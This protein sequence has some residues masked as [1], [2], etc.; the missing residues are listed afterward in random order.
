MTTRKPFTQKKLWLQ[1]IKT[2]SIALCLAS[3]IQVLAQTASDEIPLLS[4]GKP[5]LTGVWGNGDMSFINPV[6]DESGSVVCI[7]GCAAPA[8]AG[9]AAPS[10]APAAAPRGPDRPVYKPEYVARVQELNERQVEMD[11]ALS[12]GNPGLPRIGPPEGIV[13]RADQIVLLYDDLSGSFFRIIPTDGR[14]Q[15]EPTEESYLGTSV[16]W[17]EDDTLVIQAGNFN[18]ITWL[19][20][21]GAFHTKELKVTER[22][23]LVGDT[24]EYQAIV[25]DP[26]VLAEPWHMRAR[27]LQREEGPLLEP[28]PC[29]ENDL[30]H[31]VDGTHHDNAR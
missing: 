25:E 22:L 26:A 1:S 13:Q 11:P 27:T 21:D 16:G 10:G 31:V 17:W 5:D 19:I 7:V 2:T 24:I 20:D 14:L 28:L 30:D 18:D 6:V 12:C 15:P 8:A 23:R 29:V 4:N 9:T 3:G